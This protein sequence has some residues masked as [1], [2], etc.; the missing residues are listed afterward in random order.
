MAVSQVAKVSRGAHGVFQ[1]LESLPRS[2]LR[3]PAA[4]KFPAKRVA[5]S[6]GWK[7]SRV[8]RGVFQELE[9]LP[10]AAWRFPAAG[11]SFEGAI[12]FIFLIPLFPR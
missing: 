9:S 10:R 4:G 12:I 1:R 11:K 3:F 5:F 7:V 2:A 6:S 8:A